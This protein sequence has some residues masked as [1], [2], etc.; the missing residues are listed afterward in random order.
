MSAKIQAQNVSKRFGS[1]VA[2]DA[3][4]LEIAPGEIFGLIGPN[5]AGKTT[6]LRIL[7]GFM[8]ASSGDVL[9]DGVSVT[10]ERFRV[11]AKLGYATEQPRLYAD[12]SV[13][14][15]QIGRAH[16]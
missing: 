16:V 13:Q 9:V 8:L 11:Q 2:L 15:K 3:L 10:R 6:F 7:T 1:V 4:S 12:H 14:A 5:G